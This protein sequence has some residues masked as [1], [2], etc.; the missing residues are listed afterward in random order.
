MF[1]NPYPKDHEDF[2][3]AQRFGYPLLLVSASVEQPQFS[4]FLGLNFGCGERNVA[5]SLLGVFYF[6]IF[7]GGDP[8]KEIAELKYEIESN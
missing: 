6:S 7:I 2:Y 1:Q 4:I 3:D 8:I 5:Y